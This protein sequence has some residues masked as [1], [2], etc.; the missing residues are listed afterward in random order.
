LRGAERA[1]EVLSG[2]EYSGEVSWL[3]GYFTALPPEASVVE[4]LQILYELYERASWRELP[5]NFDYLLKFA[6]VDPSV[7]V[8]VTRILVEKTSTELNFGNALSD[9]FSE[10]SELGGR[11]QEVFANDVGLLKE[12]YFCAC[13][14]EHHTDYDGHAFNALLDLD[15]NFGQEWVARMFAKKDWISRRDDSRNY[16]FLWRREDY[17]AVVERLIE[18]VRAEGRGKFYS[19]SYLQN[20]FIPHE[21]AED[22]Q[23]ILDRQDAFLDEMIGHRHSDRDF[24]RTLFAVI[25][26]LGRD[27]LRNRLAT[28]ISLN[29]DFDAFAA[30]PLE[31]DSWSWSGSAVPMLQDRADFLESLL[32][33]LNTVD[34]LRHKQRVEHMIQCLRYDIEQEKKKDFMGH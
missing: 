9:L 21:G 7:V 10:H 30:L 17:R 25:R 29:Q 15:P 34:L 20:F 27:R 3:F 31:P 32:S 22:T 2:G 13:A 33:M 4:R 11:L 26:D 6:A 28:F 19:D 14:A 24:M 1:Y 12:A 5:G 8:R 16:M 23:V 18:A